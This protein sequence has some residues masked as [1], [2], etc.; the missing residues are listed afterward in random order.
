MRFV[1]ASKEIFGRTSGYGLQLPFAEP[2]G[3]ASTTT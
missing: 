2:S 1:D 3:L